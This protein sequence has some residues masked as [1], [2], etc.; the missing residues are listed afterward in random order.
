[1]GELKPCCF[2]GANAPRIKENPIGVLTQ[3]N[4]E[5]ILGTFLIECEDCGSK[6]E[7]DDRDR[8]IDMW[9]YQFSRQETA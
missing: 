8:L 6:I 2:C 9:N 5:G 7:Y 4:L 1:M 3:G